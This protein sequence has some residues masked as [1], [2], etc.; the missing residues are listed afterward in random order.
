VAAL[1]GALM[2]E[3]F[4]L[5][6]PWFL[7]ECFP[8]VAEISVPVWEPVARKGERAVPHYRSQAAVGKGGRGKEQSQLCVWTESAQFSPTKKKTFLPDANT[9]LGSP[10][11]PRHQ[12]QKG[13]PFYTKW[14]WKLR[15]NA[16]RSLN[17]V[18]W[19]RKGANALTGIHWSL[20][21]SKPRL[22]FRFAGSG[23]KM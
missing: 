14:F 12:L 3:V 22:E 6:N 13:N 7:R 11:K 21:Q 4:S 23:K 5:L 18:A 9:L 16:L 2:A 8:P 19:S 1:G 17:E 10:G 20:I 15:K